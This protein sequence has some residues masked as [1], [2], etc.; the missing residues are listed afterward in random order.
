MRIAS[1]LVWWCY[2]SPAFARQCRRTSTTTSAAAMAS[3][4]GL[5]RVL[6]RPKLFCLG[7]AQ[8]EA[9]RAVLATW[10]EVGSV[11]CPEL[12]DAAS[13]ASSD[14]ADAARDAKVGDTPAVVASDAGASDA[15]SAAASAAASTSAAAVD[16][17][18]ALS[19]SSPPS[20]PPFLEATRPFDLPAYFDNLSS[21]SLGHT[22]LHSPLMTS[23]QAIVSGQFSGCAVDLVCVADLQTS[24]RG[25]GSNVWESPAGCLL[26][27]YKTFVPLKDG[28]RL[29][30]FQYVGEETKNMGRLRGVEGGR[31]V[32]FVVVCCVR[33]CAV[34]FCL[35]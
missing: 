23:T 15:A 16:A 28:V 26:Y 21:R 7:A 5:T 18:G 17:P 20:Q 9:L 33:L 22:F 3:E 27:S 1:R 24:G 30:F 10:D 8:E 12:C 32:C 6:P 19:P 34:L 4:G 13:A 25:R 35:W 11:P 14:A 2:E 29:P 31:S